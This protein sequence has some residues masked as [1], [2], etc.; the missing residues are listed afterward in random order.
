ML[1]QPYSVFAYIAKNVNIMYRWATCTCTRAARAVDWEFNYK[2]G[3]NLAREAGGLRPPAHPCFLGGGGAP[4]PGQLRCLGQ[5]F[6]SKTDFQEFWDSCAQNKTSE[7][8]KMDFQEFWDSCAQNKTSEISK[9][10]IV[11]IYGSSVRRTKRRKS[12]KA[13]FSLTD[14]DAT[15]MRGVL[16]SNVTGQPN[17]SVEHRM[18]IGSINVTGPTQGQEGRSNHVWEIVLEEA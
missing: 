6:F 15:C 12:Q 5:N 14:I 11:I 16:C 10:D 1:I 13:H 7:I 9:A 3:S 18:P 17:P 4:R 2:F 8:S